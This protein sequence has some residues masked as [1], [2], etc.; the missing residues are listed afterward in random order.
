MVHF[1]PDSIDHITTST[2]SRHIDQNVN[3]SFGNNSNI[4]QIKP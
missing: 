2:N 4:G 3:I 1:S